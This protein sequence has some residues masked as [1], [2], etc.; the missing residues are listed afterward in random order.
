MDHILLELNVLK[1]RYLAMGEIQIHR[2]TFSLTSLVLDF[3][4]F[5]FEGNEKQKTQ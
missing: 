1:Q 4:E 5:N 2:F 3:G